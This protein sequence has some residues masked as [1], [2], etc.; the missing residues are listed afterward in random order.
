MKEEPIVFHVLRH[1]FG[2]LAVQAAPLPD[3]DDLYV[4]YVPHHDAGDRLT[5]V[6]GTAA[7]VLTVEAAGAPGRRGLNGQGTKADSR[8]S[9]E[10][11]AGSLPLALAGVSRSGVRFV[12]RV[13]TVTSRSDTQSSFKFPPGRCHVI[14]P[15]MRRTLAHRRRDA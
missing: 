13:P 12:R 7:E 4:H 3:D 8:S 15:V 10:A 6:F 2:T 14:A 11:A 9:H 1:T 5:R